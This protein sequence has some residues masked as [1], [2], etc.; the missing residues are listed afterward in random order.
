MCTRA[1]YLRGTFALYGSNDQKAGQAGWILFVWFQLIYSLFHFVELLVVFFFLRDCAPS[2]WRRMT[3]YTGTVFSHSFNILSSYGRNAGQLA[4]L[5]WYNWDSLTFCFVFAAKEL[6][7]CM[8]VHKRSNANDESRLRLSGRVPWSSASSSF[9][10]SFGSNRCY[11]Y[12]DCKV[13]VIACVYFRTRQ[14]PK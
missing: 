6:Q 9:H 11:H 10:L 14:I 4:F 2:A 12:V 13:K 8:T 5:C 1:F 7:R 3:L